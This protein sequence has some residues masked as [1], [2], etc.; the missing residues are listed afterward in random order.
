[1]ISGTD[2]HTQVFCARTLDISLKLKAGTVWNIYTYIVLSSKVQKT[3]MMI[4]KMR[5][6]ILSLFYWVFWGI[7]EPVQLGI[8]MEQFRITPYLFLERFS[9]KSYLLDLSLGCHIPTTRTRTTKMYFGLSFGHC[10]IYN[11]GGGW[12]YTWLIKWMSTCSSD[13]VDEQCLLGTCVL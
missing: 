5:M 13:K 12:A 1:M 3:W 2:T 7:F 8:S 9:G 4:E 10:A 11:W 6:E